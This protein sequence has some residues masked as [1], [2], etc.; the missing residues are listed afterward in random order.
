MAKQTIGVFFGSRSAEHDVSIITA[1]SSIIRPLKALGEYE[2][3]PIYIAKDGKWYS[4]PKLADISTYRSGEI[5]ELISKIDPLVVQ[6][7][8]GLRL[9]SKSFGR[10]KSKTIDVAFPA[11]HG[12]YGEDG[13]LMG[14]FEMA[15]L[16][17]VGCDVSSSAISM[18]K[19]LSKRIAISSGISTPV[20]ETANSQDLSSDNIEKFTDYLKNKSSLK[21]AKLPWFV[22]PAHLGSSIGITRVESMSELQSALEVAMHY[23]D[24]VIVEEGVKNLIEVTVP[25]MGNEKLRTG[26]VEKPLTSASDFFDFEKKYLNNGKKPGQKSA[27][28]GAQGYSELPAKL[29][30]GLYEKCQQTAKQI[31]NA[32]GCQGIARVD[33]LINSKTKKVY[34]N[35]INPLPG[36]LYVH[37]WNKAGVSS[38]ELTKELINLAEKRYIAKNKLNTVFETNY[39]KQF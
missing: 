25:V 3:V 19:I 8:N 17:Y 21:N 37:N 20:F 18:N 23:D 6:V 7:G 22:K 28:S 11:T 38:S 15:G 35:E 26:L 24:Q 9:M 29:S 16:P 2:I 32:I 12:T 1:I 5:E 34:F 36:S 4:H 31:Y 33:L 30:T 39:L 27:K 14:F 13:S 10:Y